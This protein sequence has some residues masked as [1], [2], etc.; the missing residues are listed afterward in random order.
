MKRYRHLSREQRYQIEVL[1]R[2]GVSRRKIAQRLGVSD[3][4]VDR[5]LARNGDGLRYA[6][7]RADRRSRRRRGR[8][9]SHAHWPAGL[10]RRIVRKLK[11]QWSPE[12]IVGWLAQQDIGISA[13]GIYRRV[14]LDS[15]AGGTLHCCLRRGR[16]TRRRRY[17]DER[18][19]LCIKGR[20]DI[21][22]RPA[23]VEKRSRIGDWETDTVVG[24]GRVALVTLTERASRFTLIGKVRRKTAIEVSRSV[25]R[26]LKPYADRVLTITSDNGSE[27]ALHQTISQALHA[28]FYF[29]KPRAA[30]QRG[31]NENT[32][33][34]IR[35]YF[36]KRSDLSRV[37]DHDLKLAMFRLNH[38]PRKC[39]HFKTPA[40]VFSTTA[41]AA[42]QT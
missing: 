17:R 35:Q 14:R 34:L 26:L 4:T 1:D 11:R 25:I 8:A 38:R 15:E 3:R 36:P 16:K 37:S 20:V 40:A 33:G 23:I 5:E 39:L 18:K 30:Y 28:S 10:W 22:Q 19:A 24:P 32:N 29:A 2:A 41:G 42:L 6:A 27:F 7:G 13:E 9:S 21:D 31:T 12:Q